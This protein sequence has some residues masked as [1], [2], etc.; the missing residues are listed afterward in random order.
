MW[1]GGCAHGSAQH[2]AELGM[3]FITVSPLSREPSGQAVSS[4]TLAMVFSWAGARA[5]GSCLDA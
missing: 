4:G 1:E 2:C 3:A 5:V